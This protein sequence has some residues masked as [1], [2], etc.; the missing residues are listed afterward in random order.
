[1]KQELQKYQSNEEVNLQLN[2]MIANSNVIV[3]RNY[4]EVLEKLEVVPL[5]RKELS[6]DLGKQ[7][8]L[9]KLNK[10]VYS[11]DENTLAKF[12]SVLQ[13][14]AFVDASV[15]AII[16]SDGTKVDYYLGT[17]DRTGT[18]ASV[19]GEMLTGAMQG[20]FIGSELELLNNSEVDNLRKDI[21]KTEN[22]NVTAISGIAAHRHD[23]KEKT[24]N[25][26]Y[27]QGLEKIVDALQGK[28]Y[29]LVLVGNRLAPLDL[30][31]I[32]SGYEEIATQLSQFAKVSF[33]QNLS[34]TQGLTQT[35][36][37]SLTEG[38]NQSFSK[39]TGTNS[40]QSNT[41]GTSSSFAESSSRQTK[42]G[43]A[44]TAAVGGA[45]V[46]IGTAIAMSP[47]LGPASL[48]VAP[49]VGRM[50]QEGAKGIGE[51]FGGSK[52][53]SNSTTTGTS[54]SSSNTSGTSNSSSNTTGTSSSETNSESTANSNSKTKGNSIQTTLENRQV[55]SVLKVIDKQIERLEKCQDIGGFDF[56]AYVIS[57][58]ESVNKIVGGTYNAVMRGERS[59]VQSGYLNTWNHAHAEG[60]YVKEYLSLFQHPQF[61]LP[62]PG[63]E[64]MYVSPASVVTSEEL[65]IHL[66]LPKKSL[67]GVQV[68]KTVEFARNHQQ[69]YNP[70]GKNLTLGKMHHMG[71]TEDKLPVQLDV[72]SL[73]MHTFITGSTGSGKSNAVYHILEELLQKRT[74]FLV[75]EPAKGEY[76]HVFG[77]K[78]NVTV[79]GTNPYHHEMLRLNPFQF[80]K[81]IHVLE[82]IDRLIEI[83]NACWALYESMPALL[84]EAIENAYIV[85]GW[86]LRTSKNE[87]C[88]ELFPTFTE[89]L[90]QLTI[91]ID[92]SGFSKE[93]QAN[94]T[95]ALLTRV[96]SL[97]NG[98][99]GE[100]FCADS[101]TY[102]QLFDEN[103]IVDL[104]R[105]GSAETKSLIMGMLVIQLQ[106][107]RMMSGQMN[108]PLKHVTVLEEA[109]TLLK[110]T[111]NDQTEGSSNMIGQSVEMLANTI[112]E[113]RTYGEGFIIV[114]QSPSLLDLSVIRN[115]NTKI[116]LRLPDYSDRELVGKAASL[117]K[118]Q[119]DEV[120]HFQ[121]GVAAVYQNSW[122]E[123]ILCHINK[124]KEE[125]VLEHSQENAEYLE[126]QQ[127]TMFNNNENRWQKHIK[128]IMTTEKT[129]AKI[130][131]IK[132][133]ICRLD[134]LMSV[135]KELLSNFDR[136]TDIFACYI[137][138]AILENIGRINV[139]AEMK[140]VILN[141]ETS[142]QLYQKIE[143]HLKK[144]AVLKELSLSDKEYFYAHQ[145]V[146]KDTTEHV[147]KAMVV[148]HDKVHVIEG[149]AK[150]LTI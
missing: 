80:P 18:Q 70:F 134:I 48:V 122:E 123:P 150:Y 103:V 19:Q 64:E 58:D 127:Q 15:T 136:A 140:T 73:A 21:F 65:S 68:V 75:I 61:S 16:K 107:Y 57:N 24:T 84:K 95:G 30:K 88:D 5:S 92:N 126:K 130:A 101:L 27:I 76:K 124:A 81:G 147:G 50:L 79:Y 13:T 94:Y 119:I 85:S 17:I 78:A 43:I 41:T 31:I 52:T 110:R 29:S 7:V 137:A 133:A 86:N 135:K 44:K 20:N 9:Y 146:V 23:N 125:N 117:S 142:E 93:L 113:I 26:H 96:K 97:T 46:G 102:K 28:V 35:Q 32:Q 66:A 71:K 77:G 11:K 149:L 63:N 131:V 51:T 72:E 100:I 128:T 74:K 22:Q 53:Q 90:E 8:R 42:D 14:I 104:S 55:K 98:L 148:P 116:V 60:K 56:S 145:H 6:T 87:Y 111:S 141:S 129:E 144:H 138:Y 118:E 59:A 139:L 12:I 62:L 49:L 67:Y 34:E 38:I 82:H 25:E 10:L 91:A 132:Q 106:E 47:F 109:H 121:R 69:G 115:T 1:M 45:A 54:T 89:V 99:Q 39:T 112:A 4:L 33:T 2:T 114:D 3:N 40:S 36:S 120:T 143:I 108:S 105:I 37:K 83:F